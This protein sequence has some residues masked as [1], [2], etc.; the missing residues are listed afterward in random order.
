MSSDFSPEQEERVQ[1]ALARS[2]ETVREMELL[3]EQDFYHG[4]V[5]RAYYAAFHAAT[6]ALLSRGLEF[7]RHSAVIA[8]FGKELAKPGLIDAQ[9][10]QALIE[11]FNLRQKADYDYT[12]TIDPPTAEHIVAHSRAV[13]DAVEALLTQ[14]GYDV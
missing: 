11:A 3:L 13:V 2:Q 6:A 7:S 4:A 10:H 9:H 14:A 8:H 5:D 1:K 12:A